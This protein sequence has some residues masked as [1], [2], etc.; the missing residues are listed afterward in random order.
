MLSALLVTMLAAGVDVRVTIGACD[1]GSTAEPEW[2]K[3]V[4]LGGTA[5]GL[6]GERVGPETLAKALTSLV[7]ELDDQGRVVRRP[8]T[9]ESTRAAFDKASQEGSATAGTCG[10]ILAALAALT[11]L[12]RAAAERALDEAGKDDCLDEVRAARK[13]K[14]FRAW[15]H[16]VG[17]DEGVPAGAEVLS[18]RHALYLAGRVDAVF[19]DESAQPP[20]RPID[21]MGL[22]ASLAPELKGG[23]YSDELTSL[24]GS[25]LA[26]GTDPRKCTAMIPLRASVAGRC[27]VV[28]V[29]A[30]VCSGDMMGTYTEWQV[31]VLNAVLGEIGSKY[32][33]AVSGFNAV[34]DFLFGRRV[35]LEQAIAEGLLLNTRLPPG[36]AND[37]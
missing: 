27:A 36:G 14:G 30:Q 33:F 20:L 35:G 16:R 23:T 29:E 12:N 10:E 21:G 34:Q 6:V 19:Q 8:A 28:P 18:V 24:R 31:L 26:K 4:L 15:L 32:R 7:E 25:L 2:R 22:L 17:L 5:A 9:V 13:K 37:P 11:R 1:A 3:D